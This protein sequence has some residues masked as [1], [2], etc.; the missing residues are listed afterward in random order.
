MYYVVAKMAR[1]DHKGLHHHLTPVAS[2]KH[3]K[4]H[5]ALI[6]IWRSTYEY[7]GLNLLK[8]VVT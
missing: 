5:E 8:S 4:V 1:V 2:Q 7:I 6:L 3:K